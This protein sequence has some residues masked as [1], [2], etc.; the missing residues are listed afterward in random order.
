M[1]DFIERNKIAIGVL[2][3]ILTL[4]S[5]GYLLWRENYLKPDTSKRLEDAEKQIAELKNASQKAPSVQEVKPEEI[6]QAAEGKSVETAPAAPVVKP[7]V[8]AT[9]PAPVV[10][11]PV[12]APVAGKININTADATEL[13]KLKGIGPVLAQ[14]I[15]DYRTKNGSFKSTDELKNV[16]GIGDKIFEKF[17]ND[18]TI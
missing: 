15:L 2:L 7:T 16:S 10:T 3:L 17:K 5:G 14:R 8:K 1:G 9:V 12:V 13:D 4:A 11:A 18:I 6:I